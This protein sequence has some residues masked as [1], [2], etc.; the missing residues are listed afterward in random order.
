MTPAP[1][2]PGGEPEGAPPTDPAQGQPKPAE[3]TSPSPH[4]GPEQSSGP[5][6]GA[7]EMQGAVDQAQEKGYLGE[8]PDQRPNEEYT[9]E[10]VTKTPDVSDPAYAERK[11]AERTG[12]TEEPTE[13]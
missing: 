13:S 7:E 9:V 6:P 12:T 1:R 2:K 10:G 8:Q 4:T 3:G 5:A 11:E